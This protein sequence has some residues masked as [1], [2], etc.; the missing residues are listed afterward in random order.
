[1]EIQELPEEQEQIDVL[2]QWFSKTSGDI[3]T[4]KCCKKYKKKK[5]KMCKSCPKG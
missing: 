2:Y 3:V 4:K 1:M 5:K